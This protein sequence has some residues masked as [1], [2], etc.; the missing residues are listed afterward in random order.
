MRRLSG[1]PRR[2]PLFAR[3]MSAAV[4]VATGMNGWL[5]SPS[6]DAGPVGPIS[7]VQL[8]DSIASGEGINY[9]FSF[10]TRT[11]KWDEQANRNPTWEGQYQACHQSKE[12]Y[13]Q[14]LADA[15]PK[16]KFAQL[17]CTGSTF[18]KGVA[19]PWSTSVPAQFGDWASQENLNVAYS[20]AKPD[21]VLVTLGA[22]DVQFVDIVI[23]CARAGYIDD[24]ACT[25]KSPNGPGDVIKKDFIDRLPTLKNHLET[26]A[27]WIEERG[28]KLGIEH[29]R[30]VFTTYPDPIPS[31]APRDKKNYCP[32]TWPFYNNQLTYLSSLVHR[33][34]DSVVT[35]IESY[36]TAH[37]DPYIKAVNLADTFDG[38]EWCAKKSGSYVQPWA[39]GMSIYEYYTQLLNPNPAAFHPTPE[40]Q[41][42]IMAA[43]K[44]VVS[45]L[46]P[47]N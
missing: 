21:L 40:G 17:A 27:S 26:L 33:L 23:R 42:A 15:L 5:A 14:Q 46:F 29:T 3:S 37:N 2:M 20:D 13:G 28:K 18:D 31:D 45:Q 30:I 36:A 47:K 11:G 38:H 9:G 16:A 43:I 24:D 12:A 34:D 6:K 44:P 22:D 8:G 41:T 19:G 4:V 25:T 35:W 7:I 10:D 1:P 32:D 39:Y